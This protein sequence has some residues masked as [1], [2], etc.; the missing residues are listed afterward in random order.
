MKTQLMSVAC[1]LLSVAVFGIAAS[2]LGM[3]C[4]NHQTTQGRFQISNIVLDS[5]MLIVA[6]FFIY[7]AFKG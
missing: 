1:F 5:I 7:T 3:Q 2:S 6:I 4:H